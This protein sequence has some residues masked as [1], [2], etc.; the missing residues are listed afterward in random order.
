MS[1][2]DPADLLELATTQLEI[3]AE[4]QAQ[5]ESAAKALEH[6]H[7]RF[8]ALL[9]DHQTLGTRIGEEVKHDFADTFYAL[10]HPLRVAIDA[11]AAFDRREAR[12]RWGAAGLLLGLLIGSAGGLI[13]W[14]DAK[15]KLDL[16][17]AGYTLLQ[18]AEPAA[19]A[20]RPPKSGTPR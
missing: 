16:A 5:L 13:A 11:A 6:A 18:A 3:A 17:I 8:E 7:A 15:R 1:T 14:V 20:A 12:L 4:N 10:S 9:R 19:A 2:V